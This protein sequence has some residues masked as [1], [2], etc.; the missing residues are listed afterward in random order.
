MQYKWFDTLEDFVIWELKA[1]KGS[2][3]NQ[4][5]KSKI[6]EMFLTLYPDIKTSGLTKDY[7]VDEILKKKSYLEIYNEFKD[8]KFGIK[9]SK[10]R[11]KFNITASQ[12]KKMVNDGYL[13][14]PTYTNH[15]KVFTGTY[16]DVQYYRAEDYFNYTAEEVEIW[17]EE[18]IRGYK[19]RKEKLQK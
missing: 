16:S 10:W 14:N 4:F 19:T 1:N 5:L 7:M 8:E 18:N 11:D 17:K 15:E 13:L 9:P 12:M 2:D 3:K 6:E